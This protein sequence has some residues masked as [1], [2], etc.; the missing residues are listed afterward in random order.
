MALRWQLIGVAAVFDWRVV[1]TNVIRA[2]ACSAIAFGIYPMLRAPHM[3][4]FGVR[5]WL[6]LWALLVVGLM[7][8]AMTWAMA[9]GETDAARDM[10][11][12]CALCVLAVA[13][14]IRQF[15]DH[16]NR[17][18][19]ELLERRVEERLA[20]SQTASSQALA[21]LEMAEQMANV[22]HWRIELPSLKLFWSDEIYRI[23]GLAK[24]DFV[25]ALEPAIAAYHPQDRAMMRGAVERALAEKSLYQWEA[26]LV[27]PDGEIRNVL[28]RG[29]TQL[30]EQGEVTGLFGVL[31][32]ITAQKRAEETLR[33]AKLA[34]ER[35]NLALRDIALVDALTGLANRRRFDIAWGMEMERAA[36]EGVSL[37]VV[38]VDIDEFKAYNDVFGHLAGDECLR[39]VARAIA[40]V[41][42]RAGELVARFG[43]EEFVVLLPQTCDAGA[44]A[45]AEQVVQAVA[46]LRLAH[47]KGRSGI[48]TVSC[49]VAALAPGAAAEPAHALLESA[50]RALYEAKQGG[51]NRVA[52]VA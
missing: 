8:V 31:L 43:G 45:L 47:P 21:W 25:P 3:A 42:G 7:Q 17:R 37:A 28:T 46:R 13:L 22:G 35:A 48:V 24:A 29:V 33:E 6:L 34:A 20:R 1:A 36:R 15:L 2:A 11:L 18:S 5:R 10:G 30:D 44:A 14:G 49:G 50:D 51:R 32:D 40:G 23:Y 12:A 19:A 27:R 41:P 16:L 4:G 9:V 52:R 38:M 39:L 26:R